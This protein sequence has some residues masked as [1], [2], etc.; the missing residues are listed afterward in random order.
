[1]TASLSA[2]GGTVFNWMPGNL[3][4]ATITVTPVSTTSYTVTVS[5]ANG[6]AS[7]DN[8]IVNVNT[9]PTANAGP[10]KIICA[11]GSVTLHASGGLNY[12]WSPGGSTN[13]NISVS[14]SSTT[15]YI[16][17]VTDANGCQAQ[18]TAKVTVNSI[19]IVSAGPD[20]T[21]CLGSTI[22]LTVSG[23]SNYLWNPGGAT[24]SSILVTPN[25]NTTYIVIG[26][27]GSGCQSSD[28]ILVTVNP[29]P[30]VNMLRHLC[31][32]VSV[33]H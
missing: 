12:I 27:N 9:L 31:V 30:V 1:M 33:Q 22:S 2:S 8:V 10:D 19:P 3:S 28:T 20:R 6:C 14:P 25:L 24:S 23:A 5:D 26:T 7:S 13:S 4:T 21:I 32:P 29:V 11:G 17:T 18:D 16:V 15:N